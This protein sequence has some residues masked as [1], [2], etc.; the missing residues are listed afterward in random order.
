MTLVPAPLFT[1]NKPHIAIQETGAEHNFPLHLSLVEMATGS[2]LVKAL[3][4][5]M[6]INDPESYFPRFD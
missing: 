4:E 5:I 2:N 6:L 1:W 3:L